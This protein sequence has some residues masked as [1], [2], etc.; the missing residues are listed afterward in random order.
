MIGTATQNAYLGN[1][2]AEHQELMQKISELRQFWLEVCELGMGPKCFELADRIASIR[3]HLQEHFDAEEQGGYLGPA[4][5]LA[6]QFADE[7]EVLRAQHAEFLTRLD[8]MGTRLRTG[9]HEVWNC[10]CGEVD[11][12]VADLLK[13]EHHENAIVQAAFNEDNGAGD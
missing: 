8:S 12:F 6:P 2:L 1:L 11:A 3:E 13:H 5:R 9:D 7:A 10:M 4:L